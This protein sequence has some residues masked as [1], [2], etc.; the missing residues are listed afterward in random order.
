MSVYIDNMQAPY[1]GMLMNHM[2]ADSTEELLDFADAIGVQR[3]WIQ[4]AG[5]Y[6]EHFDVCNTKKA[7]AIRLGAIPISMMQLG[8][9]FAK[10]PGHPLYKE[11]EISTQ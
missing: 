11:A 2:I 3:K 7:K 4:G 9:M 6:S 1:R 5:T 10:R 8:R